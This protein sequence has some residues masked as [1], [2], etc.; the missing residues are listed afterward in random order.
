MA[1]HYYILTGVSK[2][3]FPYHPSG[4]L[5]YL[6][7]FDA[8]TRQRFTEDGTA[9]RREGAIPDGPPPPPEPEPEP[10]PEPVE[11]PVEYLVEF[12][13]EGD[14]PPGTWQYKWKMEK[15]LRGEFVGQESA[16]QGEDKAWLS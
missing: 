14:P 1:E 11:P 7:E 16:P 12:T 8:A 5:T 4:E 10:E 15:E 6:E 9:E 13:G 3:G 2:D